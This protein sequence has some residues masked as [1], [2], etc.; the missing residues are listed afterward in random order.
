MFFP[1]IENKMENFLLFY[2][3]SA[4]SILSSQTRLQLFMI[5]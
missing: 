3:P 4:E 2:T 5:P 1:Q